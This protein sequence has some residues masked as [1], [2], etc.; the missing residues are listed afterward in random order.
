MLN[1][2]KILYQSRRLSRLSMLALVAGMLVWSGC[3]SSDSDDD[4][5][6]VEQAFIGTWNATAINAGPLDVLQLLGLSMSVT[7]EE[8]GNAQ[9]I[10]ADE[11]EELA[12]ISGTF[13]VDEAEGTIALSGGGLT[14]DLVMDYEFVG[15]GRLNVSFLGSDLDDLGID[16]GA[17]G[18]LLAAVVIKVEMELSTG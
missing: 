18:D 8:N 2:E 16:L 9:I 4:G 6:S 17:A 7:F 10:V 3:D 11:T 5:D 14:E 15:E 13:T 12:N 1:A